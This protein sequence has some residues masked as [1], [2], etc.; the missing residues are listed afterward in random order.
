MSLKKNRNYQD[1][2]NREHSS[3]LG[4]L[5]VERLPSKQKIAGSNPVRAFFVSK[6]TLKN[7]KDEKKFILAIT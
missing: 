7:E 2:V 3:R 5:V 1:Y 4:S 6:K